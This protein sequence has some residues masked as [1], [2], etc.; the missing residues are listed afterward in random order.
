MS[1]PLTRVRAFA[2]H[3]IRRRDDEREMDAE[4]QHHIDLRAEDLERAGLSRHEA[5]RAARVEF[6][7]VE[8]QKEA[9]RDAR[10][11]RLWDELR[12]NVA[13]ALRGIVHHP[14]QSL[15]IITT[16]TLGL[17]ISAVVFAVMNALAFRAR[18]DHDATT[19]TRI[20][21]SYRTDTSGP[22]FPGSV[23]LRD[24]L[25][26]AREMRSLSRVAGWQHVQLS[27]SAGARPTPGA[28]VTCG[29]FDVYGPVR[30]IVGRV[31]QR[32]DCDGRAAVAVIGSDLWHASF[33]ADTSVVG[34][35]LRI[36]GQTIRIVGVAS[37]F[38]SAQTDDQLWLPY[39]L[40]ALLRLGPDDPASPNTMWLYVDGRL[41]PGTTRGD[42]MTEARVIAAQ[43][44]RATPGRHTGLFVTNGSLIANPG[45]GIIVSSIVAVVFAGV[46][47][48]AVVAC[49][50]VLS[51]LL[52]IAHGRRTEM[53]LRMALGAGAPRLAAMLGTESLLLAGLA[54]AAACA[55]TYRL[56]RLLMEWIIQRP[57]NF[58]FAPDWRVFVF[59]LFTTLLAAL[60]A[61]NAPIRA[62]LSLD[63][64]S[65]L[66]RVPDDVRAG[67]RVGR[68]N[69]L[70]AAEVGGA[71]TLL[72]A[73]IALMRL[74]ARI[75][76]SPPRFDARHVLATRL[77]APQPA[78]GGW[79]SF[80]DDVERTLTATEGV[81]GVAFA[82]AGPVSDEG[83]GILKVTTT[84][85]KTRRL[86]PAIEVSPT[87]FDVFGIRVERGRAFTS[88]DA[89]CSAICPAIVSREAAREL[90]KSENP[91]G[92]RLTIDATHVLTVVGVAGDA[93]SKIAEPIQ[94]LMVYTPWRPNARLYQAFLRVEDSRG[95]VV[96]RVASVVNERFAG[97]VAAP[98]T[99]EEQLARLTD[100]FQR[101]G[102]VVGA[103]AA[104]T[105]LLAIVG[106]YGVVAL[107]ARRRLKEMGIRLALGARKADVY[108]AMVAPNARPVTIG[109]VVGAVLATMAAIESDRLLAQEFPVKLVD[110]IAFVV[111]ALILAAAVALAMLVPARRAT[112]VDPAL[113]LRQD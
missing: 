71:A 58:S 99:V 39:T 57:I 23:P 76:G 26:F 33:G 103:M 19:F 97:S 75:A 108:R 21:A 62:V 46:A 61:A 35:V 74:P 25:A 1:N 83:T 13:F 102:E 101:I 86:L 77:R 110:P 66:R 41:A 68:R 8:S 85:E 18:V 59:L 6:G 49:A 81:R 112:T 69:R 9:A 92:R 105:A 113:V 48:L 54:G 45:N 107:A 43:Q 64:N 27:L 47:C 84:T 29:F 44:D 28:L 67:K 52:A 56:P 82:T 63:L 111:A 2:R 11:V 38:S 12:A 73:S 5:E 109:L 104:I 17:G 51:I 36:N 3:I 31:L 91:I 4:F 40:R 87:Y 32:E 20:F 14:L 100:A 60:V 79:Q 72:V 89:D 16:L 80:H 7:G 96:Q 98:I 88:T 24:Y 78:A 30:P 37:A 70:M 55:L 50:S 95:G 22:S 34:R 90:W 10:G 15:I 42:V 106:V 53:A 93:T 94:A 65:T